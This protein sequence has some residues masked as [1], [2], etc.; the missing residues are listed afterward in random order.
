MKLEKIEW[1]KLGKIMV[2][3]DAGRKITK[4]RLR[5]AWMNYLIK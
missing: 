5:E 1:N 3:I 4:P 2:F